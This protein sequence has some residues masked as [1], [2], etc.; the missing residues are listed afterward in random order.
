MCVLR[1]WRPTIRSETAPRIEKECLKIGATLVTR[2]AY[3][4]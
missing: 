3:C 2:G 1:N 4:A